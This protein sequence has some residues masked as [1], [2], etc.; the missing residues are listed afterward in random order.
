MQ[1]FLWV[2]VV[3]LTFSATTFAENT[4]VKEKNLRSTVKKTQAEENAELVD[5][6]KHL[7]KAPK[8]DPDLVRDPFISFFDTARQQKR[9]H[10]L[11][12][13]RMREAALA[14]EN[15]D[16]AN[17]KLIHGLRPHDPL[18]EFDLGT[19]KLV[20][21][22]EM[23]Q[24]RIA[25]IENS[26]KIGFMVRVG[27]YMGTNNGRIIHITNDSVIILEEV[28][29]PAEELV[30]EEATLKLHADGNESIL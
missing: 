12:A 20:A 25:M 11:E 9:I 28:L 22:M 30:V 13:E 26:K 21:I 19:L 15:P 6:S 18:E 14:K 27:E 2:I 4:Q 23:G 1:Y 7:V 16:V 3:M 29:S 10:S 8:M 5:A 24:E 17:Y